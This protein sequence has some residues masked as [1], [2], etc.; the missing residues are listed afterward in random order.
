MSIAERQYS[1][2]SLG[3]LDPREA[4][5]LQKEIRGSVPAGME[6]RFFGGY[7]EAER[8]M[9]VCFPEYLEPDYD[10]IIAALEITGRDISK[11]SHRD[12]LGSLM[13]LGIKRDNIGDIVP[14][15]EKY[16]KCYIFIKPAMLNY[17]GENLTKI[18]RCGVRSNTRNLSE[19]IIPQRATEPTIATVSGL[20][21]D[22]VLSA[23]LNLSRGKT[24]ELI[25][26]ER[27][28]VNFETAAS[29][30]QSVK[31]GDLISV[32]GF[33]RYKLSE[34]RGVTRKGRISV[35]IDRYV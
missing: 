19:V 18:G 2:K 14:L 28:R 20:R 35:I 4:A 11:L 6:Y 21:L 23:A 31:E 15:G 33:G 5:V 13:G 30:S 8:T 29:A 9:L 25:K 12:Y 22:C 1:V 32:R 34:V 24:A 27:V 10:E 16:G 3:F 7:E 17:V 26:S